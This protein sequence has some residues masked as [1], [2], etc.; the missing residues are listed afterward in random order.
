MHV[1]SWSSWGCPWRFPGVLGRS[2]GGLGRSLEFLGGSPWSPQV[3][4]NSS[5]LAF[6]QLSDHLGLPGPSSRVSWGFWRDGPCSFWGFP[7][8]SLGSLEFS[9]GPC[10][11]LGS[12]RKSFEAPEGFSSSWDIPGVSWGSGE[13]APAAPGCSEGSSEARREREQNPH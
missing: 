11:L 2:R 10:G 7:W 4:L 1:S 12:P 3:D 8:L 5:R 13:A 9:R 6:R